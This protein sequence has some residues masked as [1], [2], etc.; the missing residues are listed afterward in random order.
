T[1]DLKSKLKEGY[2]EVE[3][4]KAT[5]ACCV[6]QR[7]DY[8]CKKDLGNYEWKISYEECEKIYT[9]VVILI[10][11]RFVRLVDVT[12]EQW[13]NLKYGD[14]KTMDEDVKRGVIATWLIR[15]YKRQFKD[16]LEI[17]KQRDMY[18]N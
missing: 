3:L 6:E 11:K 4:P 14:H 2:N 1:K 5:Y 8:L 7:T 15:S 17:K 10:D 12:V 9:E 16:Y 18:K 13:L